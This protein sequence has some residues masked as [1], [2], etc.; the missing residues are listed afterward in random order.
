MWSSKKQYIITL[1]STEAKYISQMHVAK[2]VLYLRTFIGE[3]CE[4]FGTPVT[5][6][7]DN[8]G[9]ITL[10]KDNKFH[11]R[12]KYINIQYHFIYEAIGD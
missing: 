12:T 9:V 2:E 3:L 10:S 8:Q 5:I 4:Q 1:S 6:N 11:V 7:C